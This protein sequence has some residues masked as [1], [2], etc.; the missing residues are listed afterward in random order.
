MMATHFRRRVLWL[1]GG[2]AAVVTLL[3]GLAI[4][5]QIK[6][7]GTLPI[8]PFF[9]L[10]GLTYALTLVY[11]LLLRQTERHQWIVDVQ[12]AVD[13]TI[14]S[15][16][17][18]L[19]GGLASLF[20][21]LYT[22]PII[23]AS[24][25][26]SLRGGLT[27]GVLTALLYSGLV[28]A[29]YLGTPALPIVDGAGMLPPPRVAL[30][31]VGLNV[32][33]FIAVA[34][35]SGYLSEGLRR[36]GQKLEQASNRI[37]DLQAFS[38]YAINSL[39][40]GL[41]TIDLAGSVL[42]MNRAG[43]AIV[44]I[45]ARQAIGQPAQTVLQLPA[46]FDGMFG[47]REGRP[48]LPRVEYLF[49]R[50]DGR[51]IEL[52]ISTAVLMTPRGESGFVITFQDV[53]E[54]RRQ[55]REA[56]VQQRLAAVGEMA[57]GIAHEIRN[58]LASMSGSIQILRQELPLTDE[59]AQLMD[60]VMRESER[61]NETIRSFLAYAR[62]Q[63]NAAARL[64]VR[65]VLT[66]TAT[67]LQN[68]PER[69]DGHT[70]DVHVADEPVWCL[71]DE[72]QLRQVVWNLATNGLRAM[73]AGGRLSLLA[74]A[75]GEAFDGAGAVTLEVRDEGVG[76]P[77]DQLEEILHPFRGGF[78]KG[79]GLGLS[80]VHRIVN[81]Y[82]G[83]LQVTSEEGSGTTVSVKLPTLPPGGRGASGSEN[84]PLGVAASS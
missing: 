8:D 33:G 49:T 24:T 53:T 27:M 81:D 41:T 63:K 75:S 44:G 18:H 61:L 9:F 48:P 29:Q 40:S 16:L 38:D 50:G 30:Y 20:S 12:L 25:V 67:L 6:S 45:P 65:R 52:G 10:I 46:E 4:V 15:A 80:I 11:S 66:D 31:T 55:E 2:R 62:P 73:P 22:L 37:A 59:Q 70:I 71:A 13:V 34:A 35:L 14:V 7:P 23:A 78:S 83:E 42:T 76:I 19:T 72:S 28:S 68:S 82:G 69:Q 21:T 60:I 47:A 39:A 58:P 32:F 74:Q 17:I 57:A 26:R 36:A 79:T 54:A 43:E 1:I 5:A 84:R 64:D 56:R 3:L 51:R 77:V